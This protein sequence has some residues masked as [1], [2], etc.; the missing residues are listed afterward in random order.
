[1]EHH[2][3]LQRSDV[4]AIC[5]KCGAEAL[6]RSHSKTRREQFIRAHTMK[7]LFRCHTCGWRGWVDESR[8][9][10]S[11]DGAQ[12]HASPLIEGHDVIPDFTI[13]DDPLRPQDIRPPLK[14]AARDG[15]KDQQSERYEQRIK[16]GT[17]PGILDPSGEV[18]RGSTRGNASAPVET[19]APG[20]DDFDLSQ[21]PPIETIAEPYSSHVTD[22]DFH[23]SKRHKGL[24][25][26]S[27]GEFRLFKSRHRSFL[28]LI[29]RKLTGK[30]PYRCHKCGWRG[31]T[32]SD[33]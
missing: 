30:R 11:A 5:P 21:L 7:R 6:R 12:E 28:E 33:S 1:M 8:L 15:E 32:G 2:P 17:V 10:Y 31:W 27:C 19:D 14:H 16:P 9:R 23:S 18:G 4:T 13:V 20:F 3:W 29:R 24:A 22:P 25:C 26:P